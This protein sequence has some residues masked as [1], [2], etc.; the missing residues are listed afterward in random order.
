MY[1]DKKFGGII[2]ISLA[3]GLNVQGSVGATGI[4][5]DLFLRISGNSNGSS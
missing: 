4:L 5:R 1:I 2:F 3:L